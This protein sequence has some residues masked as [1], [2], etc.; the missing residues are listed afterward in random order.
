MVRISLSV[1]ITCTGVLL[2]ACHSKKAPVVKQDA[3]V[4]VD[5]VVVSQQSI[6]NIIEANGTVVS[7]ESVQLHPEASGRI[8]YLNVPEGVFVNQGTVIARINDA[9]LQAQLS[10]SKVQLELAIKTEAR[11]KK[12]LAI[13]GINQSDYDSALSQLQSIQTDI[14]YYQALID[15]T[16]VKAPFSGTIG[17]R[18]V[19]IGAYVTPADVIASIQ[20]LN[21]LK[22]DFTLPEEY[23]PLVRKGSTVSVEKDAADTA[24]QRAVVIAVE[25]QANTVTRNI[26]VRAMLPATQAHPGSFVKVYVD[27]GQN[28]HAI[29]VP[30]N[31]LIPNDRRNQVVVIKNGKASFIS[32]ETGVRQATNVEI[33]QGLNPGDTVVV[34]GVLFAKPNGPMKIRSV[35]QLSDLK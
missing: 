29:M 20:Q 32:V 6:S 10:K 27:A 23:S 9:D 2:G 18:L 14:A 7:N 34:T 21:T 17:L 19:S 30:S 22:I 12:L 4:V 15:K 16:V 35:K 13:N 28:K 31:V 11:L 5:V 24:R 3:T 1:L 26:K 33:T 8:V 25:P